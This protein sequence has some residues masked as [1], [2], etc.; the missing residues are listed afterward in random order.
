MTSIRE[1]QVPATASRDRSHI[2]SLDGIR[3]IAVVIVVVSHIWTDPPIPGRF[4]VTI[5]FFLSGFLITTLLLRELRDTGHIDMRAFWVRRFLRLMPPLTI[6][7]VAGYLAQATGALPGGASIAGFL[8]QLF[9]FANYFVVLNGVEQIPDGTVVYWSLAVEEHF[10]LVYPV[11][12][13]LIAA[14]RMRR[15]VQLVIA[16]C[17]L[18]AVWRTGLVFLGSTDGR[19]NLSTDTRIDS[20][21]YGCL[22]A[23]LWSPLEDA[24]IVV[25]GSEHERSFARDGTLACVGILVL[26]ATF[27]IGDLDVERG[28]TIGKSVYSMQF[29]FQG[30]ALMP[31]FRLVILHSDHMGIRW[32][33]SGPLKLIG[34]Y[35][36][37]IYLTHD[38]I[39]HALRLAG[40]ESAVV[41]LLSTA[42][43]SMWLSYLIDRFIDQPLGQ[44]RRALRHKKPPACTGRVP[45]VNSV[46]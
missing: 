22:L 42:T 15:F 30:L 46:P 11:A 9:Y 5:F 24:R 40:V 16:G 2:P 37:A 32:L 41:L 43:Y 39:I 8:S 45:R 10:Y 33:E 17:V 35:S 26:C 18:V 34:R 27:L 36:Y 7:L 21:A 38:M 6:V 31:I 29:V 12:F 3:A 4:G 14:V 23:L 19:I 28:A 1:T 13:A 20:I 44:A 25:F